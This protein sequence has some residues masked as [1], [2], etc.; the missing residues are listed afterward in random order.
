MPLNELPPPIRLGAR[1]RAIRQGVPVIPTLVL[2][3]TPQAYLDAIAQWRP[4]G[5]FP[6]LIDDGTPHAREQIGQFVRAFE[7]ES[8]VRASEAVEPWRGPRKQ[9]IGRIVE[10]HGRSL[11]MGVGGDPA[12]LFAANQILAPGIVI[13]DPDDPAWTAAIALAAGWAQPIAFVSGF[14]KNPSGSMNAE[15]VELLASE[16][17]LAAQNTNLPWDSLGDRLDAIALCLNTPAKFTREGDTFAT[18]DR[19]GQHAGGERWAWSSQLLGSSRDAAFAAMCSLF[20]PPTE[21]WLF[22]GYPTTGEPWD[23][24][25]LTRAADRLEDIDLPATVSDGARASLRDWRFLASKPV[26]A[27][28]IFVNTRGNAPWFELNTGRAWMGDVPQLNR[29]AAVHFTHSWSAT[30]VG[31][32]ETIAGRWLERGAFAYIGSVH[33]PF[34]QAFVPGPVLTARLRASYPWAALGR[35]DGNPVGDGPVWKVATVGDPLFTAM[36]VAGDA[37]ARVDRPLTFDQTSSLADEA[38]AAVRERRFA[39]AVESLVRQGRDDDAVRLVTALIEQQPDAVTP[40]LAA[41]SMHAVFRAGSV[42]TIETLYRVLPAE[43]AS[44]PMLRDVLW[45][46][47]RPALEASTGDEFS[48]RFALLRS[49][50]RDDQRAS[51]AFDLARAAQRSAPRMNPLA[52]LDRIQPRNPGEANQLRRYRDQLIGK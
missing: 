37:P 47:L 43:L 26:D 44:D 28:L 31:Q 48:M 35:H 39:D 4:D 13:A 33:E 50:I 32:R 6:I 25:D 45:L 10:A 2:V 29:P 7:P 22:D 23:S 16:I 1:V 41:A 38:A 36:V 14:P 15:R 40:E 49:N 46:A 27:D 52:I 8:I 5:R 34:L 18:T 19:L 11:G 20:L 3:P 21:A 17:A 30:R 9:R 51:D 42:R 12:Q 24:Y